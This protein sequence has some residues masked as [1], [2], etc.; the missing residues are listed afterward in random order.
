MIPLY[1]AE[2]FSTLY[3]GGNILRGLSLHTQSMDKQAA[4]LRHHSAPDSALHTTF[5]KDA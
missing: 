2:S 4:G 3:P 5:I 1:H